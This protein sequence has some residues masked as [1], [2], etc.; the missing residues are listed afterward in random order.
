MDGEDDSENDDTD[1]DEST[2][3]AVEKANPNQSVGDGFATTSQT[4]FSKLTFTNYPVLCETFA[5]PVTLNQKVIMVVNLPAGSTHTDIELSDDGSS[6]IVKCSWSNTIFKMEEL[7][8]SQLA[9]KTLDLLHPKIMC[10]KNGLAKSRRRID[11][12]PDTF[13]KVELPLKVQ[14]AAT[15]WSHFGVKREDGTLVVVAEFEGFVKEYTKKL[16]D[17]TVKFDQ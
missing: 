12:I 15:S 6:A 13:I 14:T 2:S 3:N 7:F 16:S 11:A 5:D 8:R 4:G 17:S 10:L 9:A 1:D